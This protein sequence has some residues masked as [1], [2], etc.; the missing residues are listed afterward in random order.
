M[1]V[2]IEPES[3]AGF[4]GRYLGGWRVIASAWAMAVVIVLAFAGVGAL[5]S[6]YDASPSQQELA[7]AVIP[8][9]DP[10]CASPVVSPS[11]PQ[12]CLNEYQLLERAESESYSAW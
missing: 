3:E 4:V 8:R 11:A 5:A 9:H 2:Y 10:N 7:G 12:D 1:P 6:F